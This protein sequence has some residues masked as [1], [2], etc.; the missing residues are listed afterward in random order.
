MLIGFNSCC[1]FKYDCTVY[2]VQNIISCGV[3]FNYCIRERMCSIAYGVIYIYIRVS[4]VH[5]Y[6][7]ALIIVYVKV[8]FPQH[9][10]YFIYIYIYKL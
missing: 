2:M 1:I 7:H 5:L 3:C 10:V 6:I 4:S 9:M 8:C